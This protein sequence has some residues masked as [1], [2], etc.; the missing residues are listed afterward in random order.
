MC[1][2]YFVGKVVMIIWLLFILDELVGLWDSVLFIIMDD[3]IFKE[4]VFKIGIVMMLSGL[5][6]F[7]GVVWGDVCYFG[8]INDV[9]IEVVM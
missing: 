2:L 8:I 1:E 9:D 7:E 6:N 4:F 3:L 5:F